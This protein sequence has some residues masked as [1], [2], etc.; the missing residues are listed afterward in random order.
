MIIRTIDSLIRIQCLFLLKYSEIDHFDNK[1]S[2]KWKSRE[3]IDWFVIILKLN[4]K[5]VILESLNNLLDHADVIA[6]ALVILQPV[7]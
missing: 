4:D 6:F 3:I 1:V 7:I 5:L 2:L